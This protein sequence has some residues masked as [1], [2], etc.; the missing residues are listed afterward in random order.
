MSARRVS[1]VRHVEGDTSALVRR[2]SDPD[3]FV[4]RSLCSDLVVTVLPLCCIRFSN[5]CLNAIGGQFVEHFFRQH[6]AHCFEVAVCVR[7]RHCGDSR[8]FSICAM[9]SHVGEDPA[10]V[11]SL[12]CQRGV[13]VSCSKR[14][15]SSNDGWIRGRVWA[16]MRPDHL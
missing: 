11:R 14:T 5:T 7:I 1:C 6:V 3:S 2:V 10:S 9:M 4:H 15:A 8:T 13:T 16:I 12:D